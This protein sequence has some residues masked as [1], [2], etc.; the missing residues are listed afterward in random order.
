MEVEFLGRF[1]KDL[2]KISSK[3]V[4]EEIIKLIELF[5]VAKTLSEI[6]Q[7]KKLK[8]HKTAYRIRIGDYRLGIFAGKNKVEFA[9][10]LHRKDIYKAFP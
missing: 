2:D 10:I 6:P 5:E 1:S 9:R 7:T 8:G 3:D 4:K